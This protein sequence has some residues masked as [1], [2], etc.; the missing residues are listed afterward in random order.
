MATW[1]KI[2]TEQDKLSELL[3]VSANGSANGQ[4]LIY[5]TSGA[6]YTPA[7]LTD[8]TYLT[9]TEAG[10]S[11]TVEQT[12]TDELALLG[13]LAGDDITIGTTGHTSGN[14]TILHGQKV[15]IAGSKL[16]GANATDLVI[17]GGMSANGTNI[18][19]NK[20]DIL[21]GAGTGTGAPGNI[22]LRMY[23]KKGSGTDR[24][25]TPVTLLEVEHQR[26]KFGESAEMIIDSSTTPPEVLLGTSIALKMTGDIETD[27]AIDWDLKDNVAS[28]LSFDATDKA[29]ILEIVTTNDG[30]KVAMSGDLD[31]EGSIDVNGTANLDAVDIDGA[32]QIDAA[33][34]V[35]VDGT[36]HDVK[37]FGD[38]AGNYML[39]DQSANDLKLVGSSSGLE[40]G[41]GVTIT[42]Q[43][44]VTA[45]SEFNGATTFSDDISLGV[46]GTGYDFTAYGDTAGANML[47]D[48]SADALVVT[49]V[50]GATALSVPAGNVV[51][52]GDL[53]VSGTTTTIQTAELTVEDK[54]ITL[55][56]PDSAFADDAAA[57]TA[58]TGAGISVVTD[59][60][61][62]GNYANLTWTS[63]SVLTGWQVEDTANAGSFDIAVQT[64]GTSGGTGD[65]AGV[66][67]LHYDTS[68]L[69]LYI[70][71]A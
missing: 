17:E 53:T 21:G 5:N 64:Q 29:G 6:T 30:E 63:G 16:T 54:N 67:T 59:S 3:D 45:D 19:A 69:A 61:T 66:G 62:A 52:A 40:V 51:L 39:Y 15:Q 65:G 24:Q 68:G 13:A 56:V 22:R 57:V 10:A 35:G 25:D 70:R 60:A 4:L 7:T 44:A 31:L 46:D 55:G 9:I 34:A 47:W 28:A 37:F 12:V 36:G 11:M 58:N 27:A 38:T 8:G 20:A 48:Q 18:A 26:V 42:G 14:N 33:V 1:K 50:A 41:G 71:T 2:I 43:L 32:V 23:G 49:G